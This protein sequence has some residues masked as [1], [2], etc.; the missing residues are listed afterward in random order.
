MLKRILPA[1][2]LLALVL[3]S[4]A[5]A[6]AHAPMPHYQQCRPIYHRYDA[7]VLSK[8][9]IPCWL[10]QVVE[11]AQPRGGDLAGYRWG[12]YSAQNPSGQWLDGYWRQG[13]D[14]YWP[15]VVVIHVPS[16]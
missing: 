9:G 12:E 7:R 11:V 13:V 14:G 5:P 6:T 16:A 15:A 10:A 4:A 2:A 3:A 8:P 1:L